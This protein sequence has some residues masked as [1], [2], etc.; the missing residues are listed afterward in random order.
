MQSMTATS[1][2]T[3]AWSRSPNHDYR[4]ELRSGSEIYILYDGLTDIA[5]CETAEGVWAFE[6]SGGWK[7]QTRVWRKGAEDDVATIWWRASHPTLELGDGQRF[8]WRYNFLR[9]AFVIQ[10]SQR[11]DLIS[12]GSIQWPTSA[13]PY[14]SEATME[15]KALSRSLYEATLLTLVGWYTLL[16]AILSLPGG[17][18]YS[19]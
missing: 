9:T 18:G 6:K 3:C 8:E 14:R 16:P 13:L 19:S 4:Y 11:S 5:T 7:P 10:D 12:F 2:L 1:T 17:Q 15:Y